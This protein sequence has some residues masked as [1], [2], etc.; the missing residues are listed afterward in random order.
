M[1]T[2]ISINLPFTTRPTSILQESSFWVSIT[3]ISS[4]VDIKPQKT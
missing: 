3:P 1:Y 4:T 2:E